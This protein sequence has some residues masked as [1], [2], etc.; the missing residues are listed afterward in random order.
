MNSE[1]FDIVVIGA[2]PAGLMAAYRAAG[3]STKVLLLEKM[4]KPARKL[5]ITGKGRC[6]ITN[7]KTEEEF[8]KNVFPDHRFF[9]PAFKNFSNNDLV[10]F[11]NRIGLDTVE[12]RGSRVFPVSQKAWDVADILVAETEK[13]AEIRCKSK[14]TKLHCE[15]NLITGLEYEHNGQLR[16]IKAEAYIIATGGISYPST[17]STGDGYIWA[18]QTGHGITPTRPSLTGL[19]LDN[20]NPVKV[21]LRNVELSLVVDG[22][23]KQKEFGEMEFNEYGIDGPIVLKISRNA[24][25]ALLANKKTNISLNLKPA[26]TKEQLNNRINRELKEIGNGKTT[27]LLKKILPL[28][29]IFPFIEKIKISANKNLYELKNADIEKIIS[30]LT[31]LKYEVS[32]FRPFKEAII[33]AGGVNLNDI[34]FKTMQSKHIKNLFFAGEVIDLDANTG[35]YNLQIAFSTGYLAG[36]NANKLILQQSE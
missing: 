1:F 26:L 33:T 5:R 31:S 18:K 27:D 23:V 22:G 29:L 25:D 28:A 7:T 2:G 34:N 14:V 36:Q 11:L 15:N 6:N 3:N 35:G 21:A 30:G 17:G 8:I 20:Y 24:V 12:E 19:E 32:G 10:K 13:K 16:T 4:E 9:K